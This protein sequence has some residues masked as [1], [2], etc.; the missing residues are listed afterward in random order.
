MRF[1]FAPL[2]LSNVYLPDVRPKI[3]WSDVVK[4]RNIKRTDR[5]ERTKDMTDVN[6]KKLQEPVIIDKKRVVQ[7]G[8]TKK[9]PRKLRNYILWSTV[10]LFQN[11]QTMCFPNYDL[12]FTVFHFQ[13][14][15]SVKHYREEVT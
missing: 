3:L 10:D 8:E 14:G 15:Q 1:I 9:H 6:R 4:G 2:I 12:R 7:Q 5:P 13:N 11:G